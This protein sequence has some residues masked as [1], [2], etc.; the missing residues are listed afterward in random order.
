[1]TVLLDTH[2]LFWWASMPNLLSPAA[3][4]TLQSADPAVAAITWFELAWLMRRGR[5]GT[6]RPV[7]AAITTLAGGVQTVP[8]TPAIAARAAELP[9]TF[10]RDPVDRIIYATAVEHGLR[11]VSKDARLHAADTSGNIVIW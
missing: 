1:V 11:L 8:L 3:V 5:I 10:P 2:A 9:D 4:A 6:T 7:H